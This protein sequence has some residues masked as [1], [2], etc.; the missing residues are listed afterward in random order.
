LLSHIPFA[1]AYR[2]KAVSLSKSLAPAAGRKQ[3]ETSPNA[4]YSQGENRA[5]QDLTQ[6]SELE[7]LSRINGYELAITELQ[8]TL[9][10]MYAQVSEVRTKNPARQ[11]PA[12]DI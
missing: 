11:A 9:Q 8:E 5:L 1:V 7:L 2:V 6:L 4:G 3:S 12:T 10:L